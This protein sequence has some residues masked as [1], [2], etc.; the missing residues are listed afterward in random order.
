M[1]DQETRCFP[2]RG[3][4]GGESELGEGGRSSMRGTWRSKEVKERSVG[5]AGRQRPDSTG[6]GSKA[7]DLEVIWRTGR[8]WKDFKKGSDTVSA[9]AA[10][11]FIIHTNLLEDCLKSS[12]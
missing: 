3:E 4:E 11:T 8:P 10:H 2:A 12:F 1:Y 9:R 5:A 6:S 7:R